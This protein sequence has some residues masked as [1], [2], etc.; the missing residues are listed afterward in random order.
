MAEAG[1]RSELEVLVVGA[2][3]T[4]LTLA[5]E[6]IA[7]G[8]RCRVV[9]KA[10]APSPYSRALVVQPR[11]LELF[12]RSDLAER[13]I[14]RGEQALRVD[15]FVAQRKVRSLEVGDIGVDDTPFPFPLFVSQAETERVLAE[16]LSALG[17]NV[18]RGV[19]L[20]RFVQDETGVAATLRHADGREEKVRARYLVGADG[21]HSA[22]RKGAGL[23][24]EG[25]RY[26]HDF[27]LAD[28]TLDDVP[29]DRLS[30]YLT[31]TGPC[32]LFP[33][34]G[35]ALFRVISIRDTGRSAQGDGGEP[36]REEL[37][38]VLAR[39]TGRTLAVGEP[40]WLT[41]F[42]LHHRGVDRY[43]V[44]RVFV[45]GD[46]AHIHSPAGG[47]GMNTGIQDAYNLGWK[48]ALVLAGHAPDSLLES[49]HAERF[50]VGQR[51]L[52]FTDRLF[53]L[54]TT[55]NPVIRV[56]RTA[57][58]PTLASWVLGDRGRR[59]RAFRFVSQLAIRYTLP[60]G[61]W[62]EQPTRGPAPGARAPDATVRAA[63]GTEST[64]FAQMARGPWFT[65]LV[66]GAEGREAEVRALCARYGELVRPVF[67]RAQAMGGQDEVQDALGQARARYGVAGDGYALVRPDGHLAF[68][69]AGEALAPLER[70]LAETLRP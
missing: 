21:A 47:Q 27:L 41:R 44:G 40:T 28:V 17:G 65:L 4:G 70:Y 23:S 52:R 12:A 53:T 22:V 43:R 48:L 10:L 58:V 37:V 35:A 20:E 24:F 19:C 11:T 67:V 36:T 1:D 61:R 38:A 18:E 9:D 46:A 3:P 33:L 69:A 7:R 34:H 6:L 13:L 25:D 8:V 15:L 42:R 50:P 59:A 31:P 14:P 54:G 62:G 32:V 2:G 56:L 39:A 68:R 49:Y 16:R 63:N 60:D 66:F 30:F 45:A 57:L 5:T 51:L 26:P 64:L 55:R 29:H